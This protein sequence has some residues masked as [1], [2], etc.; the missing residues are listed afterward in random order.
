MYM[1]KSF[2]QH[3]VPKPRFLTRE[4]IENY[5]RDEHRK[6]SSNQSVRRYSETFC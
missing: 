6:K 3:E 4:S 5:V 2:F 1:E